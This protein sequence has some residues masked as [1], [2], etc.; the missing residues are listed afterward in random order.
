[1]LKQALEQADILLLVV[2]DEDLGAFA[3]LREHALPVSVGQG[4]IEEELVEDLEEL[5]DVQGLG[6]E[7]ARPISEETLLTRGGVGIE[8]HHGNPTGSVLLGQLESEAALKARA[9]YATL[10]SSEPIEGRE[11]PHHL[12]PGNAKVRI[13]HLEPEPFSRHIFHTDRYHAFRAI[14]HWTTTR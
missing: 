4:R 2:H 14:A 6:Q 13:G 1:M 3:C 10:F 8:H 5:L 7:L 11:E 12:L 9:L